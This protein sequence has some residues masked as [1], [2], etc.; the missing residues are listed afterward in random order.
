MEEASF[1]AAEARAKMAEDTRKLRQEVAQA[2]DAT[3]ATDGAVAALR[4]LAQAYEPRIA[5]AEADVRDAAQQVQQQGARILE[6]EAQVRA[7]DRCRQALVLR[8]YGASL[9]PSSHGPGPSSIMT[10]CRGAA[11][12][13]PGP[14]K[15]SP[16]CVASVQGLAPLG[17]AEWQCPC[18]MHLLPCPNVPMDVVM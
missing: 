18:P 15:H 7:P 3:A 11:P 14:V 5:E 4:Q 6:I 17:A 8:C 12:T 9:G 16:C 13:R 2:R 1:K 10:H